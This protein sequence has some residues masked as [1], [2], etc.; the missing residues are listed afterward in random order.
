MTIDGTKPNNNGSLADDP[1]AV[2]TLRGAEFR[3]EQLEINT[4]LFSAAYTHRF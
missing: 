1:L 4:L 3:Q 2:L